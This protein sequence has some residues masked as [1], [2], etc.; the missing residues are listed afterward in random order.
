MQCD[1]V[2]SPARRPDPATAL[3]PDK[4]ADVQTGTVPIKVLEHQQAGEND[5]LVRP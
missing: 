2:S 4:L 1:H 5:T 3:S